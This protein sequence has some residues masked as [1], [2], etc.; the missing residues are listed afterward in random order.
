VVVPYSKDT[1]VE[2][3]FPLT[4]PLSVA[5]VELIFVAV[6]VSAEG[7]AGTPIATLPDCEETQP[8]ELVTVK[9]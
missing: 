3:P 5:V 2:E 6:V 9:V 8:D 4:E 7:D 1:S